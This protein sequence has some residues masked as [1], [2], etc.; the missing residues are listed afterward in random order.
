MVSTIGGDA[1]RETTMSSK[2]VF[3]TG[4]A[5]FLG[6][7]LAER[8]LSLGHRVSGCDNLRGGYRDNVPGGAELYQIDCC[9]L[10]AMKH[11]LAG[12]DVLVHAAALPHEGLS[13]F[14]PS[15]ITQSIVQG[16]V[17]TF[18]AAIAS[19]VKRI[20]FCSSIAR[21]GDSPAPFTEDMP[22]SPRDPYGIGKVAAENLLRNLAEVHGV[23]WAIAIP[24][25][26]IGA[27]QKYDDP[28]RN[29]ASIMANLMLQSRQPFVYGDGKQRR[30]FSPVED[31]LDC[32]ARLTLD[33]GMSR[34]T[35]NIGPDESTSVTIIELA[36][37]LAAIIGFDGFEPIHLPS[38]PCEVKLATCSADLARA[39]LGY[40]SERTLDDALRDIVTYIRK[41]GTRPFEYHIDIEIPSDKLPET[42][43]NRLF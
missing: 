5:G 15:V 24:H 7:H 40:R 11:V 25:N 28:Y 36:Q 10:D 29:V 22:P 16:S 4:I 38:R 2:H 34:L 19:G 1:R 14:S 30:C 21:Y 20:V 35:V 33:S 8:L 43:K 26:I 41:R 13:V 12:V 42:W 23:E 18:T 6:S 37:K 39:R 31:I 17:T 9:D 32:L 27:R 3:V